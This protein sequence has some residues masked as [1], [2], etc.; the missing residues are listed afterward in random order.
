[1]AYNK[2]KINQIDMPEVISNDLTVSETSSGYHF[3]LGFPINHDINIS[4]SLT[5][6]GVEI[7]GNKS[8]YD[9]YVNSVLCGY[10]NIISGG[11]NSV[12]RGNENLISGEKNIILNDDYYSPIVKAV[13]AKNVFGAARYKDIS[14]ADFKNRFDKLS[15]IKKI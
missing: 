8:Y 15:K 11:N 10:E 7:Y 2:I 14:P 5:V 12:I 9:P 4:G 3:G 6:N 1:M 13:V